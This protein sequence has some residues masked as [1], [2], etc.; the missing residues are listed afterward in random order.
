MSVALLDIND[1]NLQLWHGE[2]LLQSPGY[3]LLEGEQYR[4]GMPA[5]SVA[6]LRPRDINSR[7]WWQL[8]TKAL[9]NSL[10]PAR[11]TADLVH[12]HLLEIHELAGQPEELILVAPSSMQREQLSLLLGIIQQC[13]FNAVGLI[14]RSVA[15]ASLYGGPGKFY[16]LEIQLHQAVISE[17]SNDNGRVELQK[18]SPLPGCG[19][20]QLQEHLVGIIARVFIRQ[21]RFDPRRKAETEQCLYDQVPGLLGALENQGEYQ[22]EIAGYRASVSRSD[23]LAATESLRQSITVAIGTPDP[24]ER[25]ILEPLAGSL[26][27]FFEQF[28]AA[29]RIADQALL[30]AVKQH[31][32]LLLQ[33]EQTLNFVTSLP[34]LTP[35]TSPP[36]VSLIADKHPHQAVT[37]THMLECGRATLLTVDGMKVDLKCELYCHDGHWQLR[38]DKLETVR[39]NGL[40][41]ESG[42]VL[43]SGDKLSTAT[44]RDI[45]LIEVVG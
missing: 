8:N 43:Y 19:W 45:S 32:P 12:A 34:S 21:T 41:Y 22:L 44:G 2:Q 13:P 39:V 1:C 23:L 26:P 25:I 36:S 18:V 20:L 35:V 3:A 28:S 6:R 38:G 9:K 24:D 33:R 4:F 7:Y 14:N 30:Q 42:Q 17:L 29:E 10:G 27:G 31:Q 16:H 15:L 11:H 5:C 40:A 37:P